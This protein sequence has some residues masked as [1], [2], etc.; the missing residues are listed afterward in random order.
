MG[1]GLDT[2]IFKYIT[3][4]ILRRMVVIMSLKIKLENIIRITWLLKKR[5]ITNNKKN[6]RKNN[7]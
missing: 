2:F 7:N 4:K 3:F 1:W 5:K 6:H